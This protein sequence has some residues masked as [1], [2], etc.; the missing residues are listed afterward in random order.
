MNEV[1]LKLSDQNKGA[2]YLMDDNKQIGEMAISITNNHLIAYHT[3]VNKEYEGKGL[4][5]VLL[6]AM[7]E[8]A[9]NNNLKVIPLCPYVNAQFMRHTELYG[10]LLDVKV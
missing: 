10:D 4:G 9:R 7:T 1:K 5:K 2:F 6:N 8:Y 3:E